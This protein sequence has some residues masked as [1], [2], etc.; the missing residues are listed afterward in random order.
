MKIDEYFKEL[1]R[2]VK[3]CYGVAEEAKRKGLDP[4]SRVEVPLAISLADRVAGLISAIY[5]QI[6]NPQVV[7]RIKELEKQHGSLDPA[8]CLVIAE[9]VAKEKFCKFKDLLEGIDAGL[10]VAFAY[11]TLGVVA[12]PLEGY[13]HL[14]LKKTREGKDYF[15]VYFSGPIGGAGRTA[16]S[17]FLLIVEMTLHSDKIL[18]ILILSW[19]KKIPI[20]KEPLK[21]QIF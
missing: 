7:N 19:F 6:N 20:L 2:K 1:E 4:K 8:V 17:I 13:T 15:S 9:E 11:L 14:Q 5:P 16:A 3:I 12:A 18:K 10:R 21:N